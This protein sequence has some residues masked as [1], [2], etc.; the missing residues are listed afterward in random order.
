MSHKRRQPLQQQRNVR[1]GGSL[2]CWPVV[3]APPVE[4][5]HLVLAVLESRL[6]KAAAEPQ[7]ELFCQIHV[8]AVVAEVTLVP[9]FS[10]LA[11]AIGAAARSRSRHSPNHWVA[12]SRRLFVHPIL[13][14]ILLFV[15]VAVAPAPA[16]VA[17]VVVAIA[18]AV[19]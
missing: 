3:G 9:V 2:L 12:V 8:V 6:L 17:V 18:V 13:V 14:L 10:V 5:L 7:H 19:H 4:L 16:V 1:P 15:V 11:H